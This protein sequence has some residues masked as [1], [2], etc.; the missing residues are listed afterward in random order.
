MLGCINTVE[1]DRGEG[2]LPVLTGKYGL[3]RSILISDPQVHAELWSCPPG[4][5]VEIPHCRGLVVIPT[6]AKQYSDNVLSR[7]E[8]ARYIIS[9][10]ESPAVEAGVHGIQPVIARLFSVDAHFIQTSRCNICSG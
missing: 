2:C 8:F 10:I 3:F 9:D 5:L 4:S 6:V 1:Y 7:P